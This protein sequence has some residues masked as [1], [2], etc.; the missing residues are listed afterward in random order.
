MS[1]LGIYEEMEY[2]YPFLFYKIKDGETQL[3][4]VNLCM[5]LSVLCYEAL[6]QI[7]TLNTPSI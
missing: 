7:Q 1:V 4:C 3:R 2:K 5:Y 6:P